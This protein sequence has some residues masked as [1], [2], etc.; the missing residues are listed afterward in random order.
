[1]MDSQNETKPRQQLLDELNDLENDFNQMRKRFDELKSDLTL[2]LEHIQS[3]D[4]LLEKLD[5]RDVSVWA[6]PTKCEQSEIPP[7]VPIENRPLGKRGVSTR[8]VSMINLKG[9]VGKTTLSANLAAAYAA[10]N[11]K[12]PAGQPGTP[13]KV[14]VIDLDFQGTLSQRCIG[15]ETLNQAMASHATSARLLYPPKAKTTKAKELVVPF[16]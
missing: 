12:Q 5:M 13:L 8:F 7:F 4:T 15:G 9:G 16:I 6:E 3:N 10:G 14:L 2:V 1:M 11:Y